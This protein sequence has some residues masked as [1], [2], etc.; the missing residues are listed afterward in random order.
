MF[1]C[2]EVVNSGEVEGDKGLLKSDRVT[3]ELVCLIKL[4]VY[5]CK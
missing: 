1:C 4:T 2:A 3:C 5:Y